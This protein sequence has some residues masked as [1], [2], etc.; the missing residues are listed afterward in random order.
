ME[1]L[2]QAAFEHRVVSVRFVVLSCAKLA[3]LGVTPGQKRL[4][5]LDVIV[6]ASM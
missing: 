3:L 2:L 6:A 4:C 5:G 1:M